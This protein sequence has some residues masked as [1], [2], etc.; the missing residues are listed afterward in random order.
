M[1]LAVFALPEREIAQHLF[2][3]LR[4]RPLAEQAAAERYR[5]PDRFEGIGGEFLRHQTD[6]RAGGAVIGDDVVPADPHAARAGLDDAAD[7]ADQCRLAGTVGAEQGEDLA[8]ADVQ[9]DA[10]QRLEPRRIGLGELRY[11][12]DGRHVQDH[13]RSR[14]TM[15]SLS[16]IRF[17]RFTRFTR[18]TRFARF[19]R[20]GFA[21][22]AR[23]ARFTRFTR[24]ADSSCAS[25]EGS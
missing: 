5:R 1:M 9:A 3:V 16:G 2:D 11:G 7:D 15:M 4:V 21:R 22:F 6:Q 20:F 8:A 19:A 18:F 17:S 13:S 24:F 14:E 23:F 25:G 10:L 12:E